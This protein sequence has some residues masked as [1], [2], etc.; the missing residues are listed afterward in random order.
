MKE[1]ERIH[2][3]IVLPLERIVPAEGAT[4][5][6]QRFSSGTVVEINA[7]VV[8]R[9]QAIFGADAESWRPERWLCERAERKRME[10]TL[11]TVG[12]W[13]DTLDE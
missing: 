6:G 5:C 8:H 9:D 4:I 12:L 11:L 7:W 13:P 10:D 2:L 3:A 1:A